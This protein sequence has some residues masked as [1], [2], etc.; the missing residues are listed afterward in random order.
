MNVVE[1]AKVS[2]C[3]NPETLKRFLRA[4]QAYGYFQEDLES[5]LWSNTKFSQILTSTHPNSLK[6]AVMYLKEECYDVLGYLSNIVRDDEY[7]FEKLRGKTLYDYIENNPEVEELFGGCMDNLSSLDWYSQCYDF[8][9]GSFDRIIDIGGSF[10]TLLAHILH[11]YP[12]VTGHLF[13]RPPVIAKARK[14]WKEKYQ[15]LLNRVVM[16]SGTFFLVGTLPAFKDGDCIILRQ[17]L[18]DCEDDKAILL[19]YNLRTA[20]ATKNV[21]VCIIEMSSIPNDPVKFRLIAD[22]HLKLNA[23]GVIR[24]TPDIETMFKQTGFKLVQTV[25]TR[26][27]FRIAVALPV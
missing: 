10:G 8:N 14:V 22:L 12:T 16:S 9:W 1:L 13:D 17:V 4:A 5:G 7:I 23:N 27:L 6:L 18:Q 19:L 26:T 20:I 2:G 21:T 25:E 15:D 11:T 24:R 3:K